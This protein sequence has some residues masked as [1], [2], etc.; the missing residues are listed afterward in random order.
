MQ[1]MVWPAL[2]LAWGYSSYVTRVVR[3]NVLEVM[4]QDY[5]RT[6]RSKGSPAASSSPG[7]S[8]ATPSSPSSP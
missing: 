1:K 6:A 4:P 7:T 2:T 8:S 3:S 5:I